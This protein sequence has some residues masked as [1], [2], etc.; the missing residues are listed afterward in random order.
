LVHECLIFIRPVLT[1]WISM[2]VN[3][4]II[5][6]LVLFLLSMLVACAKETAP[7]PAPEP[8][9]MPAPMLPPVIERPPGLAD[10]PL[11]VTTVPEEAHYLP[12]QTIKIRIDFT[13]I[14]P[15]AITLSQFPPEI[16]MLSRADEMVRLFRAGAEELQLEPGATATYNLAWDQRDENGAQVSPGWYLVDVKNV[17]YVRGSPPRATRANFGDTYVYIQYPQGAIEKTIEPNQSQTVSGITIT[18]ERVELSAEGARFYA[19]V[20]PPG[21]TPSQP[22]PMVMTAVHARYFF[23]G[24]TKDAGLSGWGARDDGIKLI[25]GAPDRPLDSI[26]S[27]A[28]ELTFTITRFGDTEGPWEFKIPL[29]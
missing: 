28:Q 14:G 29:E 8:S 20:I 25:W 24:I 21:Y 9:P 10:R 23:D 16:Q 6:L 11:Q 3:K 2:V 18:L 17:Y 15:E 1:L 12:A 22:V 5:G 4:I 27:D 19:F 26:P 7:A 13:N